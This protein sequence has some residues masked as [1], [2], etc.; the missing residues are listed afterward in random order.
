MKKVILVFVLII[1]VIAGM[2]TYYLYGGMD[3][4]MQ[5]VLM[6]AGLVLVV[7]FAFIFGIRRIRSLRNKQPVEDERSK[8]IMKRA[9]STAYYVSL[10]SWLA[11]MIFS[12]KTSMEMSTFIGMGIMLM[13]VELALAWVYFNYFAKPSE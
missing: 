1:F 5:E 7:A 9:A 8:G 4:D 13:A 12:D 10:Y 11:L 2:V 6:F 3:M